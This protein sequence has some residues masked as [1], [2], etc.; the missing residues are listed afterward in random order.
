MG[1]RFKRSWS[2]VPG[3]RLN[4]GLRSG[5][6]SFGVRGLHYTIGTKG[7]QVT[8]SLPGTG[9]SWVQKIKL[10]FRT[11][12]TGRAGRPPHSGGAGQ[13]PSYVQATRAGGPQ[14]RV[15]NQ[16][17]S[18]T[19]MPPHSTLPRIQARTPVAGGTSGSAPGM[20]RRVFVPVW[21]VWGVLAVIAI[22]I[23]CLAAA[24]IGQ[25]LH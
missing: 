16:V 13:P 23:L 8:A 18:G 21:L 3:V 1:F 15:M 2:V 12:Q 9:L 20:H 6:I 10:P 17:N 14:T 24:A 22:A 19:Q 25:H 7:S 5:S 11:A 4:L